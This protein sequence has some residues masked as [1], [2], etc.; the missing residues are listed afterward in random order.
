MEQKFL[1]FV[2]EIMEMNEVS[3]DMSYN[4]GKWNSLMML[5]LVMELEAEYG[6]SIPME[7]L[8][9]IKTLADLYKLVN[10]SNQ[11]N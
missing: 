3:M 1:N 6:V 11:G 4:E 5:T 9:N 2:A 8:G 10:Y 7:K